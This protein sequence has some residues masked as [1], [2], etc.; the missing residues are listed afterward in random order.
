MNRLLNTL[1]LCVLTAL[2]VFSC[3]DDDFNSGKK[4]SGTVL[5]SIFINTSNAKTEYK[6]HDEFNPAGLVVTA[7][8]TDGTSHVVPED[9]YEVR[10]NNYN[11]SKAGTYAIRVFYQ[12]RNAQY[13]VN[14]TDYNPYDKDGY[15][16]LITDITRSEKN[17]IFNYVNMYHPFVLKEQ[18]AGNEGYPYTM[19]FFGWAA[20][21]T[22]IG[23]PGCDATFLARGSDLYTWEVYKGKDINGDATWDT[24]MNPVLW[25]PIIYAD[26][27]WYNNWHIGDSSV[28]K[29][30]G[31]FYMM[32]SSYASGPDGKFSWESGD[33]DG[34]LVI[35]VGAVSGNGIDW[36]ISNGPV[37]VWE[38]EIDKKWGWENGSGWPSGYYGSYHR[39]SLMFD[40]RINKW[41][42][43]HD[44][45]D[46][47]TMSI[48]YW[49][50]ETNADIMLSSSWTPINIDANSMYK[51]FPNPDVIKISEKYYCVGDPAP[52]SHRANPACFADI[53]NGWQLRQIMFLASNDGYNWR[54]AG[55]IDHDSD[56]KANQVACLYCENDTMY[57]FYATQIVDPYIEYY[58]DKIRVIEIKKEVFEKW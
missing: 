26:N 25:V 33:V 12:N 39:P 46:G 48:G 40:E 57:V 29:K 42:M 30:D 21:A 3:S 10:S 20:T 11:K 13:D 45:I 2:I 18:L 54:P 35:V 37:L 53:A 44:Y 36:T 49:E 47:E 24:T 43:W 17:L 28:V 8:Y 9:E 22:N 32:L 1:G 58:L 19:W 7:R 15:L 16:N 5:N 50:A 31:K 55:W 56:T 27:V 41:R 52:V 14:V 51:N 4:P 23:W 6:V 34:D 38:P